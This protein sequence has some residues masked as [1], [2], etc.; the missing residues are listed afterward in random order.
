MPNL[1]TNIYVDGFNLYYRVLKNTPYKWLNLHRMCELLLAANHDIQTIK[2]FTAHAAARPYDADIPVRQQTYLR[3][4]RTLP[5]LQIILGQF[6]TNNRRMA[7]SE[8]VPPQLIIVM[9]KDAS[10]TET[11]IQL[12]I[13]ITTPAQLISV[14]RTDEKGSDVNLAS[15]LLQDAF[16]SRC[17]CAVVISDDSDL[18]EPLRMSQQDAGLVTGVF[19]SSKR[20][21]RSLAPFATF[22]KTIRHN[23]LAA[24]QFSPTITD[25]VGTITKPASW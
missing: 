12:P 4:L 10:G 11:P 14:V 24:S 3:A 8:L 20:P 5:N 16:R 13:A 25:A 21:S 19:T 2:Y 6:Q 1:K 15:H 7:V 17:E 22:Y 23:L 9:Q 18:A